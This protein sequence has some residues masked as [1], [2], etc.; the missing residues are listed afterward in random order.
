MWYQRHPAQRTHHA[1]IAYSAHGCS[2]SPTGSKASPYSPHN[3]KQRFIVPRAVLW[4][5][6]R[7]SRSYKIH[8]PHHPRAQCFPF[9]PWYP[10]SFQR[11]VDCG[12]L[13]RC[14]PASLYTPTSTEPQVNNVYELNKK[15]NIVTYLHKA[16]FGPVPS[17][18]IEAIEAGFFSTWPGL[19]VQL[20]KKY[21]EKST[22]T[23]KGHMRSSLQ[24]L[25]STKP[26]SAPTNSVMTTP[27]PL[28]MSE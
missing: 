28:R 24:N 20:V 22:S 21:L 6:I 10:G 27:P 16:E 17:T 11:H 1:I 8:H 15:R 14:S 19:T 9:P 7:W 13:L 26:H 4:Q 3:E 2:A 23:V 12:H 18:W 5:R 25:R